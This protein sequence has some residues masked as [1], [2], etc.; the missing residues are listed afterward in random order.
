MTIKSPTINAA[1]VRTY[2]PCT[3]EKLVEKS[4]RN[5]L[6]RPLSPRLSLNPLSWVSQINVNACNPSWLSQRMD[7]SYRW[8]MT[9][10]CTIDVF[11]SFTMQITLPRGYEK[12][13]FGSLLLF[14]HIMYFHF[15]GIRS[16]VEQGGP[17]TSVSL[18]LVILR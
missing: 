7:F 18:H 16:Q 12:C 2:I 15:H 13:P 8:S 17:L 11:Q 4:S 9:W 5:I 10:L 6:T 3:D 1:E 14:T